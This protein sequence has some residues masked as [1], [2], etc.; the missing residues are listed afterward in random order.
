MKSDHQ[1]I[2]IVTGAN[3]GLG[4]ET[5]LGLANEGYKVIMGCRNAQKA[6][7]AISDIK[8][9]APS[10]DIEYMNLDLID[11]DNVKAFAAT[12]LKNMIT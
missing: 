8:R 7:Q 3:A 1:K 6:N 9:K 12:F 2:A 10:A 4:F 5:T 11:R